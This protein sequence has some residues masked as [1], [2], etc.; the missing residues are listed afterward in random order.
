MPS[1][2]ERLAHAWNAFR[3]NRD[4][5][6]IN[7]G[8]VNLGYSSSSRPD[9]PRFTRGHDR[10]IV[11]AVYNKIAV[12][13]ASVNIKHVRLDENGRYSET[14][15]S[16]L[17]DCLTLSANT[18]QTGRAFIQDVVMSMLDE[19]CVA[20]VPVDT[21]INPRITGGYDILSMRT[22]KITQWYPDSVKVLL[23]NEQKGMKEEIIVPKK[24]T[25]IIENPFYAVMN[26]PN[27]TLQRLIRKLTLLD[28]TDEQ[29]SSGK[30]D[31]IIQLPYT[32]RTEQRMIEAEKRRKKLEEQL[33]SSK[34]GIAY[35]DATEKVTQLNRSIENNFKEQV[36]SFT[37]MLYSQLGIPMEVFNGTADEK[38]RLNYFNGT[39]EPILTAICEEMV[40]KFLTKT[41]RTKR[42]S[43]MFFQDHFK[44]VPVNNIADIADKF[45]RN[46]ILTANEIRS[47]LGI[48][49]SEDPKAD[50]L[51]NSNMPIQDQE[52]AAEEEEPVDPEEL[53]EARQMLLDAGLNEDDLKDL[54][55]S[56][57]VD[58]AE[59]HEQNQNGGES[60]E[61]EESEEPEQ[62][63]ESGETEEEE[64]S[65][66]KPAPKPKKKAKP[67]PRQTQ[68]EPAEPEPETEEPEES[69]DPDDV[70]KARQ[71]LIE[72]GL[73]E[74]D[75]EALSDEEIL[76][77]L[78]E[79]QQQQ[80]NG[81]KTRPSKGSTA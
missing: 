56:E 64:E 2:G 34:Y 46:E 49:P 29:N 10:S 62:P 72:V 63:Q 12:D 36:D 16:F 76:A 39:I 42:Q 66:P 75:L 11:T 81:P 67:Q 38:T 70:K 41:A 8:S 27:S 33:V 6:E 23:Y 61:T 15:N 32:V 30:L 22:G 14:M 80:G 60:E 43:I 28:M 18:D 3:N 37:T 44:L 57:I 21:D 54:S 68:Q 48:K 9:R 51:R 50:E 1:I 71:A 31:L 24:T 55:D 7:A 69:I 45:T 77:L 5:S 25:A 58:L 35:A 17:N 19:G 53:K 40:R 20:I 79:L 74:E 26:E 59:E 78:A 65:E 52:P 13:C 73:S 4:P 47:I